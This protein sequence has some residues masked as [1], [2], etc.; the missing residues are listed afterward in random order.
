M[1]DDHVHHGFDYI[2]I[3]A[4][5]IA[6]SESFYRAAFGWT[7]NPYGPGY[8]GIVTSDGR[9]A[10]GIS[11]TGAINAG[12]GALVVLFSD[13]IDATHDAVLAAGGRIVRE[14]FTF[15]GGRRFHFADP[16]GNELAVWGDPSD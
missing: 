5:D 15:P 11:Q 1:A 6:A 9:E 13:D 3:P 10:G 7:F 8:L 16:S 2:E 14:T 4:L 12:E